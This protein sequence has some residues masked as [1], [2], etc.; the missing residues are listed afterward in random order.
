MVFGDGASVVDALVSV[1][2]QVDARGQFGG[3]LRRQYAE[4]LD[5]AGQLIDIDLSGAA[6]A[7]RVAAERWLDVGEVC[8]SVPAVD[9]ATRL[10]RV[11][12]DAVER[13]DVGD[14]AALEAAEGIA[15]VLDSAGTIGPG[16]T[17]DLLSN[18]AEAI[19]NVADAEREAL[20]TLRVAM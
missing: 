15:R 5:D 12:R 1:A 17:A 19:H 10:S 7:Y 8:R 14:E 2:E 20:E 4:F 13:G 6:G 18:L 16:E 9:E 3:S 11:R